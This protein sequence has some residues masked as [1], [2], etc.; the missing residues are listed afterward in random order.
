MKVE[1]N[2]LQRETQRFREEITAAV[3]GV[4][5]R[6]WYILGPEVE[7]FEKEFATYCGSS[8]AV[9]VANGTEALQLAIIG[10]GIEPASEVIT[11]PI[12]AAFTALG[13]L[14]AGCI[15][16]FADV[17][18]STLLID[19]HK[20]HPTKKT[21]AI[22]PVHLYGNACRMDEIM[23]VARAEDL[24][25]IEDACQAHGS[26]HDGRMLGTL[27]AVG[28]F[29]FYPTK[30]LGAL[31]DGGMIVTDDDDVYHLVRMLRNGGQEGR[32]KHRV[33][34]VNSRLDEIQAAVL[35]ARLAHLD[36]ENA[37]RNEIADT[38]L[39]RLAHLPLK[40][41]EQT[42]GRNSHLFPVRVANRDRVQSRLTEMGVSTLIHYPM[43]IHHQEFMGSFPRPALPVAEIASTELLSLPLYPSLT[44]AEIDR[45]VASLEA[46]LAD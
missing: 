46:A 12:S 15:P 41:V 19:P 24:L 11:S 27:G 37:R 36:E 33:R 1:F 10:A 4:L 17:D 45:V 30:N 18:D 7:A 13:I 9:G 6:G 3:G 44:E 2:D 35:R 40:F 23:D 42:E 31:G 43:P 28:C 21:R 34:G 14:A 22:V 25:V 20:I 16:V 5:D 38:Y 32:Y 29:S 26:S 39:D 8:Y